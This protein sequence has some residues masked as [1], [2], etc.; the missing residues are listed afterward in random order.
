M[1]NNAC[2]SDSTDAVREVDGNS[3]KLACTKHI[4]ICML[5]SHWCPGYAH[6]A[7]QMMAEATWDH[8]AA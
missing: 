2:M 6:F 3:Q 8:L 5:H 1:P 7:L 4:T